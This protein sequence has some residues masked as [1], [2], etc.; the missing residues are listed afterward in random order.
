VSGPRQPQTDME[1]KLATA[2]L[3]T[4]DSD[5]SERGL[6]VFCVDEVVVRWNLSTFEVTSYEGED[7]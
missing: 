3:W 2:T 7:L 1:R 6:V 5:P 4:R